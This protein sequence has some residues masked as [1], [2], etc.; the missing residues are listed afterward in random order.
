[1]PRFRCPTSS[2]PRYFDGCD[3]SANEMTNVCQGLRT[4]TPALSSGVSGIGQVILFIGRPA[5]FWGIY[6]S[7]ILKVGIKLIL[8]G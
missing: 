5:V 3:S 8:T 7:K 2:P 1:M 4:D 6:P